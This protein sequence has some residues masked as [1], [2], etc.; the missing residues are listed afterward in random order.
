VGEL[1]QF[2]QALLTELLEQIFT[3]EDR[4]DQTGTP[5]DSFMKASTL[6]K[7]HGRAD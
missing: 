7:C 6:C 1:T 4:I 2:C 5:I 3:L